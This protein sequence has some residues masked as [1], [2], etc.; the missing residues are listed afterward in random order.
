MGSNLTANGFEGF[1]PKLYEHWE[2]VPQGISAEVIAD[3]WDLSREDARRVLVRV[4]P[5]CDRRD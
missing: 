4:A 3:E 5:P 2:V 1:S